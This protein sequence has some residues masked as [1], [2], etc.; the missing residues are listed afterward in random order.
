MQSLGFA[1]IYFVYG[2]AFFCMGLVIS[3]EVGRCSDHRLRHALRYLAAFGLLHGI[4]EWLDMFHRLELLP[5]EPGVIVLGEAARLILLAFSFIS[6]AA[7]GALL[8]AP[9]QESHRLALLVPLALASLWAF[10]SL[11]LRGQYEPE[12]RLVSVVEVWGRYSMAI[13]ASLLACGGLVAQQRAFRRAGMARFGQDSLW[14]AVAFGWYGLVGQLFTRPSPLPPSTFLNE[15]LFL[16]AFGFPVQLLRAAA[17]VVAT[18]FVIRFLRSF[19][20]EAQH[21]IEALQAARLEEAER[22]EMLRGELLHRV[23]EAQEAERTRIARELHDETGQAL[24]ALGLGLRG[25]ATLLSQDECPE[26][27]PIIAKASNNLRSLENMVARSLDELQRV[28]ADLRPSHLDDLG[29]PA[30]L[31][32]YCNELQ[33]RAHL[34]I[35]VDIHGEHRELPAEVKTALFR[36]AQEALTNVIRHSQAKNVRVWLDFGPETV[37]L[38]VVDDGRGFEIDSL[39]TSGRQPWGLLGMEERAN[40]LGGQL[41]LYSHPGKGTRVH[42]SI[43]IRM[44]DEVVNANTYNLS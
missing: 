4:H 15:E 1:L 27:T 34:N 20:V 29:L 38:D 25:V 13:P 30:A 22:R 7:F 33:K 21:K 28:I 39:K 9:G 11:I 31:R 16:H 12:G 23:V 10:G 32:W 26:S 18:V 37:N 24:T 43:P 40:L 3:L 6:L 8:L 42:V 5:D 19:E 41:M 14:A 35:A 44:Q 17:A 2:L 36:V